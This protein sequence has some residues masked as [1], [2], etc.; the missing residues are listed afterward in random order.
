MHIHYRTEHFHES[1][2]VHI[3]P[4][5]PLNGFHGCCLQLDAD[6]TEDAVHARVMWK[7]TQELGVETMKNVSVLAG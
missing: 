5:S 4:H 1:T 6:A 7:L 2:Q 3:T